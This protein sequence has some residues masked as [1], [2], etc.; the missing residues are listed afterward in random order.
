MTT[1]APLRSYRVLPDSGVALLSAAWRDQR[2][3]PHAHD[4]G[5]F[6]VTESGEAVVRS[7]AREGYLRPGRV[8][9]IPPGVIHAAQSLGGAPWRYRALYVDRTHFPIPL[10]PAATG[11]HATISVVYA[12]VLARRLLELHRALE[13]SAGEIDLHDGIRD[14]LCALAPVAARAFV[15]SGAVQERASVVEAALALIHGDPLRRWSLPELARA[16]GMSRFQLCR[17]FRRQVGTSPCAYALNRRIGAAHEWLAS[18]HTISQVA[19]ELG[20]SDQSHFT[21]RFLHVY[22]LTPGEYRAALRAA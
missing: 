8:L 14:V 20:F 19:Y 9:T 15:S 21:R 7:G 12:P 22:G 1:P 2:F 18:T 13:P 16:V 4:Y 3:S 11:R 5:V 10:D 17:V 6:A